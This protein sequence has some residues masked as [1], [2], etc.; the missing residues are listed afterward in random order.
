[1]YQYYIQVWLEVRNV[2]IM[3]VILCFY[4]VSQYV[5]QEERVLQWIVVFYISQSFVYCI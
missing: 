2:V 1:M 5:M 4:N 3:Y